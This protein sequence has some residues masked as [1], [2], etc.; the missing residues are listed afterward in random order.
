MVLPDKRILNDIDDRLLIRYLLGSL[1]EEE[2]ERLDELSITN[3][4]FV[5]RLDAAEDDLVDAFVRNELSAEDHRQFRQS[6]LSSPK[7][8]QKVQFA[9]GLLALERRDA[10]TQ[11]TR[12]APGTAA[13]VSVQGRERPKLQARKPGAPRYPLQW[14]F[15]A[16]ALVLLIFGGYL[17]MQNSQLRKQVNG[18]QAERRQFDQRSRE[19]EKQLDQE[20]AAKAEALNELQHVRGS[21]TN[22]D[23]IKTVS[24]LLPPPLRGTASIPIVSL[25]SRP[26]LVV[27]VLSLEADDF[28]A[29]RATLRD[30]AANHVVWSSASLIAASVGQQKTVSISF[31]AS[32]LQQRN[33]IVDLTAI[34][35]HGAAEVISGYPFH[36]VLQ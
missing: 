19:L 32:L 2:T 22:L 14:G 10:A 5:E 36:V 18:L 15:A 23:Q 20:S 27:L 8:R 29:Y 34:P 16:A 11:K 7:R 9:Q 35:N 12:L 1:P 13:P 17:L 28:P 25:R 33:Y 4:E 31:R 21:E 30:P 24:L 3:T 6:Y 26:D